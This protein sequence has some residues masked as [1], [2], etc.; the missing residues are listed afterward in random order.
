MPKNLTQK[1]TPDDNKTWSSLLIRRKEA[2]PVEACEIYL[3]G[4]EN[5]QLPISRIPRVAEINKLIQ[6]FSE[7]RMVPRTELISPRSYFKML[8]EFKFPVITSIRPRDAIDYYSSPKPDVIHEYFGHA[9]FL[10]I[11][12]YANF[13]QRLAQKAMSYDAEQQILL[14]RLFWFT[15]EFGLINTPL[16]LRVFGAGI[17]PSKSETKHALYD[18]SAV[19]KPLNILD[20]LCTPI[21]FLTK[22][23]NYYIIPNLDALYSLLDQDLSPY[24]SRAL[25]YTKHKTP[26]HAYSKF[27]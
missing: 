6:P 11:A 21:S 4:L 7:W 8:A 14:G 12:A 24:L 9:P 15:I 18:I 10:T 3:Q 26:N 25:E 13:L 5:L 1:Y 22:Q 27:F 2:L 16:G 20:I 19:R 17:I 23:K